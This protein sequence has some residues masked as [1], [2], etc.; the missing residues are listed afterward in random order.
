MGSWLGVRE[1]E[2]K[3][4]PQRRRGGKEEA[5]SSGIFRMAADAFRVKDV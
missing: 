2:K 4:R 3:P 1:H 5:A